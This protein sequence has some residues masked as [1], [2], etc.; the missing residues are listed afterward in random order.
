MKAFSPQRGRQATEGKVDYLGLKA[1]YAGTAGCQA[2]A[3]A[4]SDQ[5]VYG[6]PQGRF[7]DILDLG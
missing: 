4:A 6:D 7:L 3:I 1:G 2:A 5:Y